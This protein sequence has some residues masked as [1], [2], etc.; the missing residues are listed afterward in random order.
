MIWFQNWR[1]NWMVYD[2]VVERLKHRFKTKEEFQE[3]YQEVQNMDLEEKKKLWN[4]H[5]A[6]EIEM[7]KSSLPE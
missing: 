5:F 7:I 1:E 2:D 3:F 4:S 6:C